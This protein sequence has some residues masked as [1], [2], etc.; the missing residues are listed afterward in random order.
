MQIKFIGIKEL[1]G[2]FPIMIDGNIQLPILGKVLMA[3]LWMKQELKLVEL[4][5]NDLLMPQIELNLQSAEASQDFISRRNTKTW[6][7][8]FGY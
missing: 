4:Y 3:L 2:T 7:I 5:K 6:I 8:Y 1:S